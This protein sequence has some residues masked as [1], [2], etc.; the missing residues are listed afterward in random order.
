MEIDR[1]RRFT[2]AAT[3]LLVLAAV[4]CSKDPL[5]PPEV[6]AEP[7]PRPPPTWQTSAVQRQWTYKGI[8]EPFHL[9]PAPGG[10]GLLVVGRRVARLDAEGLRGGDPTWM[11]T[12]PED[13]NTQQGV[14]TRWAAAAVAF[15]ATGDGQ[16]EILALE[17]QNLYLISAA[18]GQVLRRTE[19]Q[20]AAFSPFSLE[21]FGEG[22]QK[23]VVVAGGNVVAFSGATGERL[24]DA[25][26]QDWAIYAKAARL[27]EAGGGVV[28]ALEISEIDIHGNVTVPERPAVFG[29]SA[30]GD[31]LFE[32]VP[33]GMVWSIAA[34]D[35][36]GDGLDEVVAGTDAGRLHALRPDGSLLW[37]AEL[38]DWIVRD[39]LVEDVTGDGR[40]EIFASLTD[41]RIEGSS[42]AVAFDADGNELWRQQVGNQYAQVRLHPLA[43]G[44]SILVYSARDLFG[45]DDGSTVV[46]N[47]Q[48]G[49]QLWRSTG[50]F[51]SELV[52]V[53]GTQYLAFGGS[54]TRVRLVHPLTGTP[55]FSF[56][57]GGYFS[58]VA[59][60]D[61][62]GDGVDEILTGDQAGRLAAWD[63]LG[64][65][66]WE[67]FLPRTFIMSVAAA[68]LRPGEGMRVVAAGMGGEAPSRGW[69]QIHDSAGTRLG[70]S[71]SDHLFEK[72]ALAD[73]TSDGALELIIGAVAG[74]DSPCKLVVFDADAR[75]VGEVGLPACFSLD[76]D[77]RPRS[78]SGPAEIGV[79]GQRLFGP[80]W[81]AVIEAD[82][83]IRWLREL[84]HSAS[85]AGF[86]DGDLA[87]VGAHGGAF[88][89]QS[90]L[91]V[92]LSGADGS[93]LWRYAPQALAEGDSVGFWGTVVPGAGEQGGMAVALGTDTLRVH[94]LD[95]ATGE[96]IWVTALEPEHV[97]PS[98]RLGTGALAWVRGTAE[99]PP[100][101]LASGFA[102]SGRPAR[103]H[104]LDLEGTVLASFPNEGS[105]GGAV[106]LR[107]APER[108]GVAASAG[109]GLNLFEA[110]K[111]DK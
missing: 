41:S 85:W 24:W 9:L 58:A 49:A 97:G 47:P 111:E 84:D 80:S 32:F 48:T 83:Q 31:K 64:A 4:S 60:A 43:S 66:L 98:E 102:D 82:L 67:A 110:V 27:D 106:P 30:T 28:V 25:S 8:G 103:S 5:V 74:I 46:V 79:M 89:A 55:A 90:E 7:E 54:D 21:L 2:G 68:E 105:G 45:F 99:A 35:L 51:S 109:L 1:S 29:F 19:A 94:L 52:R 92:R 65:R 78:E 91:A 57:G 12:W 59:A 72:V 101:L 76:L 26:F 73:L 53:E 56:T 36:S 16:E 100:W 87:L 71:G 15:D 75:Y 11:R 23:N 33:A 63:V 104:A 44:Q 95:A 108:M 50:S 96:P 6:V 14:E 42:I 18:S 69:V 77:V 22:P 81:A 34:G 3:L 37:T 17:N 107:T 86:V 70:Y 93:E 20:T 88:V 10:E 39:L 38:G 40:A 61:L 62:D 13:P